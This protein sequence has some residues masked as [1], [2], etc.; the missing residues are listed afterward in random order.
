MLQSQYVHFIDNSKPLLVL[1]FTSQTIVM[2]RPGRCIQ[3]HVLAAVFPPAPLQRYVLVTTLRR[4]WPALAP[5]LYYSDTSSSCL[6]YQLL[7]R[8]PE[9]SPILLLEA[10]L[11]PELLKNVVRSSKI[12]IK[13]L[14][15]AELLAYVYYVTQYVEQDH[16]GNS[17][18]ELDL[19]KHSFTWIFT[20]TSFPE[21]QVERG[22]N[23]LLV[24]WLH[25][26]PLPLP[27]QGVSDH[28][29]GLN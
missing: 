18:I 7:I 10:I 14:M 29:Y 19:I 22:G 15:K 5:A 4:Q 16:H 17:G 9:L 3:E 12:Q 13:L 25:L 2:I 11:V 26:I 23:S 28:L 6:L 20:P 1:A 27:V 8:C 24:P 21:Q